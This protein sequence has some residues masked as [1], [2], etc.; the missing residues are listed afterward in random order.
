MKQVGRNK[1]AQFRHCQLP[2]K[3]ENSCRNGADVFRP[4]FCLASGEVKLATG[5]GTET[6]ERE[7]EDF[8]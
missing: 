5:N 1:S 3:H 2:E 4:T 8:V 6:K 7:D